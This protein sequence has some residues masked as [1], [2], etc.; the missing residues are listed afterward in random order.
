MG[1]LKE[2]NRYVSSTLDK[3]P[4][5][6]ADLVRLDNN[7]QEWKFGQFAEALRQWTERNPIIHER[8]PLVMAKWIDYSALC[9]MEIKLRCVYIVIKNSINQF[10][11]KLSLIQISNEK[12]SVR[13]KICFNCT[14]EKQSEQTCRICNRKDHTFI[15]D[16]D[17]GLLL[18]TNKNKASVTYPVVLI[19]VDGVTCRA[20]LDTASGSS[21]LT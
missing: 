1:K 5:I 19:K 20:L 15:C 7:W 13:K 3:I 8:R 17:T 10:N 18:T 9:N 2:I 16:R 12:S 21:Q 4:G 11:V 6:R 14:G